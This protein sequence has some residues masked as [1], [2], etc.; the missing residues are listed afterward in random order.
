MMS[1]IF[2]SPPLQNLR[3]TIIH[4]SR[5]HE[6]VPPHLHTT[7][8]AHPGMQQVT[9]GARGIAGGEAAAGLQLRKGRKEWENCCCAVQPLSHRNCF[10]FKNHMPVRVTHFQSVPLVT[11]SFYFCTGILKEWILGL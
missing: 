11:C 9:L 5:Q 6:A 3:P 2:V 1:G 8:V 7:R 10:C 4:S